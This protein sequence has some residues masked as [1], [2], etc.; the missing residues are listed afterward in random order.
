MFHSRLLEGSLRKDRKSGKYSVQVGACLRDLF[1]CTDRL[2]RRTERDRQTDTHTISLL[3][4]F[5]LSHTHGT[6]MQQWGKE[7]ILSSAH[8]EAGR[9]MELSELVNYNG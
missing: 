1:V 5:S 4:P 8:N 2:G 6:R 7:H 9:G 3:S